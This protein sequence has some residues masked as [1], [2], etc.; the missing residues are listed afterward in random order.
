[1]KSFVC[2]VDKIKLSK[3]IQLEFLISYGYACKLINSK[4]V[5]VNNIKVSKDC[6]INQG[7]C[8]EIYKDIDCNI[9]IVYEDDNII[10]FDKPKGIETNGNMSF[11]YLV[12]KN[13][14]SDYMAV[15]RLDCDTDGL[16][17]FSK[18]QAVYDILIEEIKKRNII[19]Y[20]VAAV[21]GKFTKKH[22]ILTNYIV[23]DSENSIVY[24][25]NKKSEKS[26]TAITEYNVIREEGNV[27]IIE[28]ILHTGR[29]HQIRAV[30]N[31]IN[32]SIVGDSKYGN[33]KGKQQL[34]AY[35]IVFLL[36]SQKL[37]DLNNLQI[38]LDL[39]NRIRI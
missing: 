24:V 36:Q 12:N 21:Y 4:F 11:E 32:H 22:D 8:V 17:I 16:I 28:V 26:L 5:R 30:M 34:T 38:E 1:M 6:L 23:K 39:S 7:D 31:H 35:K 25:N 27:S 15:H 10:V 9:I 33:D 19:K 20:Y 14:S 3:L 2:K 37:G 18:N 29:T 13:I